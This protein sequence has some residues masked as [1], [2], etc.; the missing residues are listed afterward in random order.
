MKKTEN[1]NGI[2]GTAYDDAGLQFLSAMAR[3]RDEHDKAEKVFEEFCH[4][5]KIGGWHIV[6]GWWKSEERLKT[7]D[8]YY[9]SFGAKEINLTWL[10]SHNHGKRNPIEGELLANFYDC[11]PPTDK[12]FIVHVYKVIECET[13]EQYFTRHYKLQL[14]MT[15][16]C[17]YENGS[18]LFFE[19]PISKSI[20][21]KFF[22]W[23]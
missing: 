15:K 18:F 16:W 11:L 12:P 23:A 13:D 6:D 8:G 4:K 14:E 7:K 22:N 17:K 10:Q 19:P 5:E 20:W 3:S 9:T 2:I 21:A 1:F